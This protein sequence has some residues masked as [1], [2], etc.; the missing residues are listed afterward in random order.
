MDFD[1]G[2]SPA[3]LA[4]LLG[5]VGTILFFSNI[6]MGAGGFLCFNSNLVSTLARFLFNG[7][8]LKNGDTPEVLEM[9]EDDV[10]E[11]FQSNR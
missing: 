4:K 11:V 3:Y 9:E 5:T 2:C 8:F 6:K 10:I 7:R 1:C